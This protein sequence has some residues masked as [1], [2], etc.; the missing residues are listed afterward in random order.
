[1]RIKTVA[2]VNLSPLCEPLCSSSWC[3]GTVINPGCV[4]PLLG[5]DRA[6]HLVVDLSYL[7]LP[8]F[9]QVAQT[10]IYL[11]LAEELD[12]YWWVFYASVALCSDPFLHCILQ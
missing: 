5:Q 4:P 2:N 12:K 6:W 10:T 8:D 7:D 11:Y 3:P 9:F 1:M